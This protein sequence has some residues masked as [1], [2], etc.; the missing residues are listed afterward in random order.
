MYFSTRP[1]EPDVLEHC[2]LNSDQPGLAKGVPAPLPETTARTARMDE[3]L[4]PKKLDEST[5]RL[6]RALN[7]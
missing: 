3:S 1:P 7:V 4:Q 6:N 2:R 5:I